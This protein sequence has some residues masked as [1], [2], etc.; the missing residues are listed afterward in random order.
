MHTIVTEPKTHTFGNVFPISDLDPLIKD[1]GFL[2]VP[3]LVRG[4]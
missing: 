3:E 1:L 4:E 2:I